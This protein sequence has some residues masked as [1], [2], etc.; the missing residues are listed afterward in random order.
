MNKM[1]QKRRQKVME[2]FLD[3]KRLPK[4]RQKLK[5]AALSFT[6]SKYYLN[7]YL[8]RRRKYTNNRI[9]LKWSHFGLTKPFSMGHHTHV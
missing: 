2:L 6:L 9:R 5:V 8:M 3:A 4:R 7:H 1:I